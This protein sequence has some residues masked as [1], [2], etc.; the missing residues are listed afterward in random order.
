YT[1]LNPRRGASGAVAEAARNLA[2][3]GALPTAV[4]NNLN[5][6][7]PLKP[8]IYHQFREAVMGMRDACAYMETPVTGGNVSFYNETDGVAIYP[9][10]VIGM[11]GLVDDVD[12]VMPHAFQTEGDT[13]FLLG[14]NKGELGGSEY[15]YQIHDLVAGEPPDVDLAAERSLQNLLLATARE[16]LASSAHDLS[17]GGLAA[18]LAECCLGRPRSGPGVGARIELKDSLGE[19]PLLFGESH[20]RALVSCAADQKEALLKLAE[21]HGVPIEEIGSVEAAGLG[22]AIKTP[23]N[24]LRFSLEELGTAYFGAIPEAMGEAAPLKA[25]S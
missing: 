5:F 12:T 22:L 15:L 18:A 6:G 21:R 20:G 10:P 19:V 13:V 9:T 11:V 23:K 16:R 4:T 14:T 25:V 2:C 1:Y 24:D 3:V 17:E 8:H 7:N